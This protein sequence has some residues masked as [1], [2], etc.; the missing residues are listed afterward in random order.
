MRQ[1][2]AL[3]FAFCYIELSAFPYRLTRNICQLI[4]ID[5]VQVARS[6]RMF[7]CLLCVQLVERGVLLFAFGFPVK[8]LPS[9]RNPMPL[10][11]QLH[12]IFER[13]VVKL[14]VLH[15]VRLLNTILN[16]CNPERITN[17]SLFKRGLIL[18]ICLNLQTPVGP[19]RVFNPN[20]IRY[21][22]LLQSSYVPGALF[23]SVP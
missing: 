2:H 11:I 4:F 21:V 22:S 6:F 20:S 3:V 12:Q 19:F 15:L 14:I 23:L 17:S 8:F 7:M 13:F 9:K 18:D 5:T 16:D 1:A 10:L